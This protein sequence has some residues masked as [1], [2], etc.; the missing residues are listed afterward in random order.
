MYIRCMDISEQEYSLPHPSEDASRQYEPSAQ[1]VIDTCSRN[2]YRNTENYYRGAS[3]DNA[4]YSDSLPLR[5]NADT[6]IRHC[7]SLYMYKPFVSV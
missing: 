4:L 3:N 1:T 5:H 2:A 6:Q 7:H